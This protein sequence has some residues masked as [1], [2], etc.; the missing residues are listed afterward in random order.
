MSFFTKRAPASPA[1]PS[2][3][4]IPGS[5]LLRAGLETSLGELV[6]ALYEAEVPRTVSNF[7]AL[8][9]GAV[10]WTDAAGQR[11]ER[12]LYQD[13]VFHRVID[14][15]MAQTGDPSGTGQGGPGWKFADELHPS[16][17]HDR[18]GVVSM[19][20]AGLNTN[21][22]QFF[23]LQAPAPDLDGKHSVFGQVIDGFDVLD[24]ICAVETDDEY[25]P[26]T[27]VLL[28]RVRLWRESD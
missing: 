19:A 27:P 3:G 2:T 4:L 23:I 16:L 18:K 5:G 15:F 20:N 12:P 10:P 11:Q 25:R 6:L 8:A 14:G 26:L 17:R 24:R 7:A 9:L 13:L 22:S 21:G 28:R 1:P